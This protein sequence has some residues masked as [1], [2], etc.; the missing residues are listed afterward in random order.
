MYCREG[1]TGEQG[2]EHYQVCHCACGDIVGEHT[3]MF[4]DIGGA[5]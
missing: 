3:A 1:Y 4:A 5:C 2:A